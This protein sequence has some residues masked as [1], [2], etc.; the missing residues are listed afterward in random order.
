M[1][2]E[3][4]INRQVLVCRHGGHG[5]ILYGAFCAEK[6]AFFL[7]FILTLKPVLIPKWGGGEDKWD[8]VRGKKVARGFALNWTFC[9]TALIKTL[10]QLCDKYERINYF[11]KRPTALALVRN[12]IYSWMMVLVAMETYGFLFSVFSL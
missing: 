1:V 7:L 8:A 6:R 11:N 12:L 5:S 4:L 10:N 3:M 9:H 2:K